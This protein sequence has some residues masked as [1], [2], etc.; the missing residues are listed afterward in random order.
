[1]V[2]LLFKSPVANDLVERIYKVKSSVVAMYYFIHKACLLSNTW[3][4]S[5]RKKQ[6]FTFGWG[7]LT[8]SLEILQ[9][10]SS[11]P[12]SVPQSNW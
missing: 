2:C 1:M 3:G 6:H 7:D 4:S 10:V 11:N 12:T 9:E 5:L 8:Q